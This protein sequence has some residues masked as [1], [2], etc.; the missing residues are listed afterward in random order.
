MLGRNQCCAS[1]ALKLQK[2]HPCLL[3]YNWSL[4]SLRV[5]ATCFPL[6]L[7]LVCEGEVN[8]VCTCITGAK[9]NP[10]PKPPEH[11]PRFAFNIGSAPEL[12]TEAH[13]MLIR[14]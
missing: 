8:L 3:L 11:F 4:I 7:V 10:R 5:V 13:A 2:C 1:A 12:S 14:R 6:A 9:V